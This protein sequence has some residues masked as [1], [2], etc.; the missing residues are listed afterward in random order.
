M[1][2]SKRVELVAD[3]LPGVVQGGQRRYEV[4]AITAGQG[5]GLEYTPAVLESAAVLFDGVTVFL[6]HP[7]RVGLFGFRAHR[8]VAS[9][10]GV[11]DNAYYAAEKKGVMGRLLVYPSPESE[12]Y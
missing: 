6:D 9:I 10:L 7:E 4:A 12:W 11:L 8:K 3:L 1:E 2:N 5:N